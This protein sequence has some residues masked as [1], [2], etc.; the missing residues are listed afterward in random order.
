MNKTILHHQIHFC[1]ENSEWIVFLHGAG[2][3]TATWKYQVEAFSPFYNLLL[4]DLRDHGKSK[5]VYPYFKKYRFEIITADIIQVLN[6]HKIE[7]AHFITLSFGSVLLQDLSIRFPQL[8]ASA[9]FA[10]GIFKANNLIRSFVNLARVFNLILPYKWMYTCFSW[11]LMPKES[12]KKS[13]FI[14]Q[15]QAKKLTSVEYMKWVGLYAEFFQLLN[16]FFNQIIIFKGLVIMGKEDYVFLNAAKAF[17]SNH[18]QI[19]LN[20]IDNAGHICNIDQS[21]VFNNVALKFIQKN[22]YLP[23]NLPTT[24]TQ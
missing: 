17:A 12:H 9:V 11:L 24:H 14:Y 10:G 5:G 18:T 19:R 13:R 4:L 20:V 3:S 16:R 15:K 23:V 2:G 6:E 1:S 21:E 7:K 8:I 22:N